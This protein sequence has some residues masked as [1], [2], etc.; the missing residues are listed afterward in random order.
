MKSIDEAEAQ[1]RFDEILDEAQRQPI[2]IR[3]L[4]QDAAVVVSMAE[5]DRLR[6]D[7]IRAFLEIRDEIATEAAANGLTAERLI[8]LFPPDE[9]S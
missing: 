2:V 6:A 1:A 5:Y 3:R 8:N 4:G 7:T 9:S